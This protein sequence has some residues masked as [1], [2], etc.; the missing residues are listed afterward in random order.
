MQVAPRTAEGTADR[1]P[2]GDQAQMEQTLSVAVLLSFAGG[3]L[4]AYTWIALDGVMA[5]AQTANVVLIGVHAATGNWTQ[6]LN[7][8]PPVVAFVCGVF[9]VCRLRAGASAHGRRNVALLSLLLEIV[10]LVTVMILHVRLPSVAGTLGISFAAAMQTT[11]FAKVERRTFSSVMVT[12]NLRRA[13]EEIYAGL[14][15][16]D[17]SALR[18]A[19]VLLIV[20]A[21][22]ALGAGIGAVMTVGIGARALLLPIALLLAVLLRCLWTAELGPIHLGRPGQ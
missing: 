11:S 15:E 19:R 21:T 10:M 5:N 8:I 4:D 20:C 22:F 17:A 9:V 13:A 12:G 16:N 14:A 2:A 3:A 1:A 6:A 18:Q 7:H